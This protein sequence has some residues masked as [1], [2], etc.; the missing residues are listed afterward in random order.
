[1]AGS[2]TQ[3]TAVSYQQIEWLPV[4]TIPEGGNLPL[5]FPLD[6]KYFAAPNGRSGDLLII[7]LRGHHHEIQSRKDSLRSLG[8]S[9]IRSSSI[10]SSF[11]ENIYGYI[12]SVRD[13]VAVAQLKAVVYRGASS[14]T[15]DTAVEF[16]RIE[17]GTNTRPGGVIKSS[18]GDYFTFESDRKGLLASWSTHLSALD[19]ITAFRS[20]YESAE[21]LKSD[22]ASVLGLIASGLVSAGS[23]DGMAR[24]ILDDDSVDPS[25]VVVDVPTR[26]ALQIIE[27]QGGNLVVARLGFA[28]IDLTW[29]RP[30]AR[31]IG[32]EVERAEVGIYTR[33]YSQLERL[34]AFARATGVE[35]FFD[36]VPVTAQIREHGNAKHIRI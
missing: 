13:L 29:H 21:P 15:R 19:A 10:R 35:G 6:P 11:E 33:D 20:I 16:E 23:G 25:S 26:D 17:Y 32:N 2:P 30:Y 14:L 7:Q 22:D 12:R 24:Q 1:M 3:D 36:T 8:L 31:F 18:I 9:G 5:Q 34:S 28:G 4:A 27:S